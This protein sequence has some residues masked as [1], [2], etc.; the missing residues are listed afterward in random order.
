M[1]RSLSFMRREDILAEM[2]V[3]EEY[4]RVKDRLERCSSINDMRV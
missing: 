4:G 2:G 1:S 3:E